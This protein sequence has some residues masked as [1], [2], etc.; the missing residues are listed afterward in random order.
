MNCIQKYVL[1][2]AIASCALI[3]SQSTADATNLKFGRIISPVKR[4]MLFQ[5]GM[6][7]PISLMLR[8]DST[9][10][11]EAVYLYLYISFGGN[12]FLRDTAMVSFLPTRDSVEV[13]FGKTLMPS[14]IG[15]Y[16]VSVSIDY[17]FD[18]MPEDNMTSF[19]LRFDEG[20]EGTFTF[21]QYDMY[22]PWDVM[23]STKGVVT[24]DPGMGF[25]D[26]RIINI[27]GYP[28]GTDDSVWLVKN[29]PILPFPTN[30]P[31]SIKI[32]WSKLGY[33]EGQN[34]DSVDLGIT[35]EDTLTTY[36]LGYQLTLKYPV[37]GLGYDLG[38]V[39]YPLDPQVNDTTKDGSSIPPEIALT[40]PLVVQDSVIRGCNVPNLDLDSTS[41][42]PGTKPGYAG[43]KNACVP[44][45]T[46]NSMQWLESQHPEIRSNLS[47]R[48][49]LEELSELM[50]R[51]DERGVIDE[52]FVKGKLAYIDKY[53]LPIRVKFQSELIKQDST[54]LHSPDPRYG[55]SADNQSIDLPGEAASGPTVSRDFLLKEMKD[56]EDLE[57]NI[58]W[59]NN[60]GRISGGHCVVVT[61]VYTLNGVVTKYVVK[62]DEDQ[63]RR[64]GLIQETITF[65]TSET[66]TCRAPEWDYNHPT[67]GLLK[68]YLTTIVSESYDPSVTFPSGR[69]G[70]NLRSVDLRILGNPTDRWIEFE[71][72]V[73]DQV[74]VSVIDL[75][76]TTV[77]ALPAQY[78]DPGNQRISIGSVLAE[79][80]SGTYFVRVNG[81]AVRGTI[82]LQK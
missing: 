47:H 56:S 19:P 76:G 7:V 3:V 23:N 35:V 46:A 24:Y 77:T 30:D 28:A 44:T 39:D 49:K 22:R 8:N 66:V 69:V 37:I 53:K 4:V 1:T 26:V 27:Y 33:T 10:D 75:L 63:R 82:K 9:F 52:K 60:D 57:M 40:N 48:E 20:P 14:T 62:H 15:S 38:G 58:F 79:L 13:T 78:R 21:G 68:A 70:E 45:A 73:A 43:D 50:G 29:W 72:A 74:E 16:D 51:G 67:E 2:F 41:N 61:G 80:P 54:K 18:V 65:D 34:I 11:A 5:E 12:P 59:Y 42:N 32:D 17:A 64:G 25:D 71:L 36:P 81:E 6:S 31:T 55:H